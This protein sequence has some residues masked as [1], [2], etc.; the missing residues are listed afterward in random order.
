MLKGTYLIAGCSGLVGTQTLKRLI[1]VD[2]VSVKA[3]H[4]SR[5]PLVS[6]KNI[7][8]AR[9][10]LRDLDA[11]KRLVEDVDYVFMLAAQLSTAPV[12]AKNPVS[13]VTSNMV[14]NANILEASYFSNV[15]K[16]I[17]LSS[18]TG[19]PQSTDVLTE[20][21]MF[22]GDPPD[23]HFSVGWMS[24]YTEVLCRMY[25]TKLNNPMPTAILRPTTIYGEHEDFDFET[26][27]MLPALI[28][29]VVEGH[30]PIVVWGDGEQSRDLIY[31]DDVV[32]ACFLALANISIH[33]VFNI[34]LGEEYTVNQ[35][36]AIIRDVVGDVNAE[37]EHD[38]SKPG[39]FKKKTIALEK[40][41]TVLGFRA[42][43]SLRDGIEHMVSWY[44][45]HP[46]PYSGAT[47]SLSK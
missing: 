14:M 27:H 12:V 29:K 18:S 38:L 11:C 7:E 21:H 32:D 4:Y 33:D 44:Q 15:K 26:A 25:S 1:N 43:T 17:W 10:D 41:E 42:K 23:N 24:R 8:H 3:V 34:G 37:I 39:S 36:L 31:V 35:I 40:A 46:L 9:A 45:S 47:P 6:G 30:N 22:L 5:I 28:R 20:D 19:Y 16:F 13:H 2:G